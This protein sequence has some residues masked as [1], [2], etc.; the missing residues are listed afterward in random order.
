MLHVFE[1][2]SDMAMYVSEIS[3]ACIRHVSNLQQYYNFSEIWR[4]G[5]S[6]GAQYIIAEGRLRAHGETMRVYALIYQYHA[7]APAQRA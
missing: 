2:Y 4:G 7:L 3:L 1:M 6:L 5:E